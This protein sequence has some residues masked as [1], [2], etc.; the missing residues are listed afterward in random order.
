VVPSLGINSKIEKSKP[1]SP[2]A[3]FLIKA[4]GVYAAWQFLYNLVFLP[5]GRLDT[6]LSLSGV[7][8]AGSLLALLG[9]EVEVSGRIITCIGEKGVEI[10]NG[11]N[12]LN[13]LGLYGGFI[14]AYPGPWTKRS[15]F[16][17]IGLF[18]LFIANILRIAFFA[19]FNANLPQY[20]DI[21]HNYSSYVFFYPIVLLFWYLWTVISDEND[22]LI[23]G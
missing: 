21:A 17:M 8:L 16:L 19:V 3:L 22:I 4:G 1:I 15:L 20:F 7:N 18:V 12:G 6:F 9:W 14:I 13:L 11:C 5:D 10:Q 23:P 2:L